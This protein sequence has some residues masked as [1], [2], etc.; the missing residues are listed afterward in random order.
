MGAN[1]SPLSME[2]GS[3]LIM[4]AQEGH[5]GCIKLIAS[6]SGVDVRWRDKRG[7]SA[8]DMAAA[9]GN[10]AV[11][12]YLVQKGAKGKMP[13]QKAHW[14]DTVNLATTSPVYAMIAPH[15]GGVPLWERE[16]LEALEEQHC[17]LQAAMASC[18]LQG[19]RRQH[20]LRLA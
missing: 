15:I 11:L 18:W 4:A 17:R 1:P 16:P 12:R 2:E 3:P 14:V 10:Y 7:R 6:C 9:R 13:E 20:W 19:C 5:L 8:F